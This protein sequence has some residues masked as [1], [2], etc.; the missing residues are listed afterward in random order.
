MT[1]GTMLM[2][3]LWKLLLMSMLLLLSA[4]FSGSETAMFSLTRGQL[5]RMEHSNSS[6]G[7]VL[8]SL[9]KFPRHLLNTLLL[10][11][12][13]VNI[14]YSAI[15]AV[16]TFSLIED[17]LAAWTLP[18]SL[19]LLLLLILVGEVTPK[20]VAYRL[21]ERWALLAAL[22]ISLLHRVLRPII[23]GLDTFLVVPL[24]RLIAPEHIAQANITSKE[25]SDLLELSN[26]RGLIDHDAKTLLQEIM[27]LTDL[28]VG[29][30]M[31]PRVDII[32][33]DVNAPREALMD[34]FQQTRL[35]KLPIYDGD[36]DNL[37]GI[38]YAKQ[39]LLD[40]GAD[41]R[42]LISKTLFVPETANLEQV[43]LQFRILRKQLAFVVDEYGGIVGLVTLQDIVEEI[44][45]D[46]E[47]RRETR[48]DVPVQ[49][50]GKNVY[51]L[52]GNLPIHEWVEAFNIPLA[53][54]RISTI[55]GFVT[56]LLGR[57]P[58]VG[59]QA[60]YRNLRFTVLEMQKRRVIKLKLELREDNA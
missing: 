14:A 39:L 21:D 8:A 24:T 46:I 55:G 23:W 47:E 48:L 45:G 57:L 38:V 43:L 59:N 54:Q 10:G 6:V 51:H 3:H 41:L 52:N 53:S 12:M 26:K 2:A 40:P 49:Q 32:A 4:F 31:L 1:L 56:S 22:P 11:N 42:S 36:I 15:A 35:K 50:I 60:E 27:Q 9:M 20:L 17:G 5:F 44:V 30:I 25:L 13:V 19:F 28:T 37:L 29:E 16:L 18:V 58:K 34:K 33:C 7:H